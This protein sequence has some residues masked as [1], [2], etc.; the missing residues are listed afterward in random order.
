[1]KNRIT[2]TVVIALALIFSA[3]GTTSSSDTI[4]GIV[5]QWTS[6]TDRSENN[7]TT[8]AIPN[9]ENYTITF[10]VDGTLEGKADCNNFSGTYSQQGGFT[11]TIGAI[12]QAYCGDSS[13]DAQYI[14]LLGSVSAGGPDGSGG[15]AL[16]TP[17]GAQRMM[18]EN[19]GSAK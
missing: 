16:E 5:W 17:G 8:T 4:T 12:T 3:C 15:L 2:L 9:P 6:L 19:G 1:M 13:M 11:V 18:F 10:N 14:Q 7:E